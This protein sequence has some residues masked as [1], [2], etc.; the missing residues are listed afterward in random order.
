V[1]LFRRGN[2]WWTELHI[3]GSRIRRSTGYTHKGKASAFEARLR[4]QANT[5][6]TADLR[7][8]G[9]RPG[10]FLKLGDVCDRYIEVVM[11]TKPKTRS[12]EAQRSV[13][14]D[15]YR[16]QRIA[17]YFGRRA[18]LREVTRWASIADFN[19]HLLLR[20]TPESANRYLTFLRAILN[21]AYEWGAIDS[22]PYVRLNR[23]KPY[24][25]RYLTLE[26]EDALLE[27]SHPRLKDFIAFMLD[28]GARLRE[29]TT[30]TWRNVDLDRRPR[31]AVT[32]TK[33]KN[34][35][36]RTIPLPRRTAR[37][38]RRMKKTA[39]GPNSI[40]FSYPAART[41]YDK[42]GKLY[43]RRGQRVPLS[44]YHNL[45]HD[46]RKEVGL[47][48]VHMHD[49]RHTYAA[50]LVR[51]NVPLLAVAKL[52]GHRQIAM[53]MRYAHLAVEGLDEAV[54]NLD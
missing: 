35:E 43:A 1:N 42:Y 48:D 3:D 38:L 2:V 26:E 9:K 8:L 4:S 52:L 37:I 50:K 31:A 39:G 41:I 7:R 28:T 20:M 19:A 40:V 24:G 10:R 21:K 53:T 18:P 22:P 54:A 30:L 5:K 51:A 49:L 45:W 36:S 46:V 29:A 11:L 17:E 12:G 33:T 44:N 16:I 32:F 6:R 27:S 23:Q 47:L 13:A 25:S 15:F 14:D 34:G